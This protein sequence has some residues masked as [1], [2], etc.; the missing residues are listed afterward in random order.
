MAKGLTRS[1]GGGGGGGGL[2]AHKALK[3]PRKG[4]LQVQIKVAIETLE[5]VD[6]ENVESVA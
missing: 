3:T 6:H 5:S 1:D 2:I 4:K